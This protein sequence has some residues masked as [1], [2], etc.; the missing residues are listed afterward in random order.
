VDEMIRLSARWIW[1]FEYWNET[2][3]AIPYLDRNDLLWKTDFRKLFLD[4]ENVNEI[5]SRKLIRLD[6][7]YTDM[8]FLMEKT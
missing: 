5:A 6:D 4:R 2:L 7:G 8:T 1:C 3:Q